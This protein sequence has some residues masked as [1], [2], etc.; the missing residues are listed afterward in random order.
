MTH[1]LVKDLSRVDELDRETAKAVHGGILT[2]AK[3]TEPSPWPGFPG[4][5]SM[6]WP[7]MNLPHP[8]VYADGGGPVI[9]PY[10]GNVPTD[11]RLV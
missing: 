7:P 10:H 8:P 3:P 11:P 4:K 2:I 5:P 6:P 9:M 1:L